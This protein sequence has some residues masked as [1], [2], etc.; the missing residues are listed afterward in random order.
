MTHIY[1]LLGA[2]EW[3]AAQATGR[4]EGSEVDRLDGYIH[5]ST[6]A[7]VAET[8]RRHFS[9]RN[10]LMLISL[11]AESLGEALRWEPSRGGDLFPHLYRPL[12]VGEVDEARAVPLT[13][14]GMLELGETP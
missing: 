4:F 11:D 7:Q 2:D 1:K 12:G 14:D 8:A 13:A 5:L 10:D 6:G 3:A 9:G